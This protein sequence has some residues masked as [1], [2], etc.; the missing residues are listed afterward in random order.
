MKHGASPTP[1]LHLALW[2]GIGQ[3]L[4]E[5]DPSDRLRD[6]E[7]PLGWL[8]EYGFEDVDCHWKGLEMALLVGVTPTEP[9]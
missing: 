3:T 2:A 9:G 8:R 7:T 5:E 1:R 4:E 6:V